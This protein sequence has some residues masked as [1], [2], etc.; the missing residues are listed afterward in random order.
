M[1]KKVAVL[2]GLLIMGFGI[3]FV[4][5]GNK[6]F[7]VE[8]A[9]VID[10]PAAQIWS[11]LTEVE[12]WPGWWPGVQEARLTPDWRKGATL[13]LVLRGMPEKK[14]ARVETVLAEKEMVW[15]RPGTLGSVTRTSLLLEPAPGGTRI[16]LTSFIRGPQAFLA[17]FTGRDEF[18][19]YHEAV[20][21]GLVIRL[22][23]MEGP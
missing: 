23:Q 20:L 9:Q 12:K 13:D 10:W 18:A 6:T 14:P 4:M 3:M 16:S 17:G 8:N 7:E 1:L 21:A 19:R 11:V 15:E 2:A 5:T 22:Q